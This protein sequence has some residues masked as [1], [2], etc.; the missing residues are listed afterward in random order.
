MRA[1][2]FVLAFTIA[3]ALQL[4]PKPVPAATEADRRAEV[5]KFDKK[6]LR[7][8]IGMT[9]DVSRE[10]LK[11]PD[12]YPGKRDFDIAK[13]PPTIDFAPNRCQN[14]YFFPEDNKGL[15]SQ[16]GEVTRGPNGCFYMAVGDHRCKDGHVFIIEYDPVKKDQRVA[17]DVGQL[18]GWKPGQYVDGKIHGKMD[19]MPDGDLTAATWLGHDVT[20]DE[21][22]HGYV[23]GGHL[24]TYNVYTGV[25]K[26]H[27][28]PLYGDSWPYHSIDP[29]TGAMLAVGNEQ[30]F[31]S[32]DVRNNKL[33]YGGRPPKEIIWNSRSML[34]DGGTGLVYSTNTS[35]DHNF[36]PNK[37]DYYFVSFDQKTNLFRQLSCKVPTNPATGLNSALRAYTE[38]RNP[39]D[40]FWCMDYQGTLFK[41]FPDEER[42]ELTGVNWDDKGVYT[43][44]IAMSPRY[45]YL[46]YVLSAQGQG[47]KWGTPVIQ[48]DTKTGRKKALAFLAAFYHETYGYLPGGTFGVE[49]SED[50]SLLV[51]HMNG[52]FGPWKQGGAYGQ[53]AIFA[54]HI[55]STERI[56]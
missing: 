9:T 29:R 34:L 27:G 8:G 19:V 4:A 44:S 46:Y 49:L 2:F 23:R 14:P 30:M 51:V 7:F 47:H 17:V 25:A 55:P 16:W 33:L 6:G 53:C 38:T 54:I 41:F 43:T 52:Y 31:M 36:T 15:W 18:C 48:Y 35:K 12:N 20:K 3:L 10:F 50:G 26:Y 13:T 42:T 40:F 5:E 32:Y 11:I 28:V 37:E 24:L 21:V 22:E 1:G 56:E 45:R 39:E